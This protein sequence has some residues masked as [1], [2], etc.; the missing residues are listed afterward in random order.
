MFGMKIQEK[1]QTINQKSFVFWHSKEGNKERT[2][3]YDR[4]F[5]LLYFAAT[6]RSRPSS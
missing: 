1:P 5:H 6:K 3:P 4:T 2:L